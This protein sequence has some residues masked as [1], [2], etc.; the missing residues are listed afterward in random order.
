MDFK[1]D[2]EEQKSDE[3][4][5]FIMEEIIEKEDHAAEIKA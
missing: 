3:E 1:D 5:E 4:A 2:S